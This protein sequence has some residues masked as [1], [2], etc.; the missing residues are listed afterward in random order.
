MES[1]QKG[2][3]TFLDGTDPDFV[4]Q[5]YLEDTHSEAAPPTAFTHVEYSLESGFKVGMKLEIPN[6]EDGSMYWPASVIMT[7]GD[8]LTL[9]YVGY[10][11][12][13]SADFWFNI[14]SGEFHPIGWCSTNSKKLHPPKAL[15]E[16]YPNVTALLS[17][18]LKSSE[19]IPAALSENLDAGFIPIDQIKCGMKLELMDIDNPNNVWIVTIKQNI[20]GR[21]L[22]HYDGCEEASNCDMWLFYLSDYLYPVGF[23]KLNNLQY[24]PPKGIE[25]KH[26]EKEWEMILQ[27]SFEEA[28]K[29]PFPS[30]I[31]EPKIPLEKLTFKEGMKLEAV[32][33]QNYA[34]ICPA[35]V[36]KVVND[37]YFL[38]TIDNH[39]DEQ[40]TNAV[41]CCNSNTPFVFPIKWAEEHELEVKSPKGYKS[42]GS[43]FSWDDYL[44]FCKAEA[45]PVDIFPMCFMNMGFETGMKLETAD[46]FNPNNI[47]AATIVKVVEPLM[48][49]DFDNETPKQKNIIYSINSFDIFPVG[50]CASNSYPLQ[51]PSIYKSKER[52]CPVLEEQGRIEKPAQEAPVL[53]PAG[54]QCK[55]WCPKIYFNHRC[56][57]GPLLSKSRL[58]ELPQAIGPG[59]LHLVI[60]DVIYRVV[61]IAYKSS[62]VLQILQVNGKPSPGMQPLIIKAKYKGKTNRATIEVIRNSEQVEEFC[63]NIC[64]KLECCPYLFGPKHVGET[65]P[66][67]C[68]TQTKTK[69]GYN[70][71]KKQKKVG[72]P[73]LHANCISSDNGEVVKRGPGRKKKRKH[74]THLNAH[75]G[76]DNQPPE[77]RSKSRDSSETD[78]GSKNDLKE[79]VKSDSNEPA[80][81]QSGRIPLIGKKKLKHTTSSSIVTRGAKLPNFGLWHHVSSFHNRRGRPRTRPMRPFPPRKVGRPVGSTK[82]NIAAAAAQLKSKRLMEYSSLHLD[83]ASKYEMPPRRPKRTLLDS[84]PIDWTVE[85]VVKYLQKTDYAPLAPLLKEQEIDGPALLMLNIFNVQEYLHLKP[86]PAEKFCY[87]IKNLKI[88]FFTHYVS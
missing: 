33:I 13:R 40:V 54:Q 22:L 37:Y 47:Y 86:E 58:A 32:N 11:D 23:A 16:K 42:D 72:R 69:F 71:V 76:G 2:N 7:C 26:S 70:F 82:K 81:P 60:Q 21:L 53:S 80:S 88:E 62:R 41:L 25:C 18:E 5:D 44:Q 39:I 85:D 8:L 68:H 17:S 77:K 61:N 48:W 63:K 66:S 56:F 52:S 31:F 46:P 35:T 29:L 55:S 45:A 67:N 14:K 59:P 19:S 38:V 43:K 78:E 27:N 75:I 20:G 83:D 84:N 9:R 64:Q 87:L 57:T 28:E 12:D 50:W 34:E 15:L 74:W 79:K 30:H 10:G 65:C 36:T 49:V 73:P 4:W 51:T 3:S 24:S 6:P 1:P